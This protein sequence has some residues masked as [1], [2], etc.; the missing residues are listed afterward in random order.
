[1]HG[2]ERNIILTNR[3]FV[4]IYVRSTLHEKTQFRKNVKFGSVSFMVAGLMLVYQV[5]LCKF[6]FCLKD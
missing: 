6:I 3:K 2:T 4:T 5:I 1:M